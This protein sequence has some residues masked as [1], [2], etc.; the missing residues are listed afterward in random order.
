M[1]THTRSRRCLPIGALLLGI[2]AVGGSAPL[3]ASEPDID[4]RWL[5]WL[6]CWAP[7]GASD[8]AA[9]SL[10][11]V[12]RVCV[13]PAPGTAGVDLVS[14]TDGRIVS[15]VHIDAAGA[16]RPVSRDGCEGWER[17]EWS[18][19]GERVYMRSELICAG[20]I[21][22]TSSGVLAI[23][24]PTEW[25]DVQVI[26]VRDE[27]STRVARYRFLRDTTAFAIE[28][29]ASLAGRELARES[30]R[31]AA[32][33]M[34]DVADVIEASSSV[35]PAVV[36]AWL[37]QRMPHLTVDA[38]DLRALS[39][40]RVPGSVIDL[41][42]ALSR[43]ELFPERLVAR[44][45]T[46]ARI[47]Q[48]RPPVVV[49]QKEP[50]RSYPMPLYLDGYGGRGY[51]GSY[52][53]GYGGYGGYGQ[54][55]SYYRSYR[56]S[57]YATYGLNPYLLYALY[58]SYYPFHTDNPAENPVDPQPRDPARAYSR[59][60]AEPGYARPIGPSPA[61]A[62][63]RAVSGQGYTRSSGGGTATP[64]PPPRDATA[65]PRPPETP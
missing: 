17:G 51:Y 55:A 49:V 31:M 13:A 6:G 1:V 48:P 26:A 33:S 41:V 46:Y 20:G 45:Y 38:G 23:A 18:A 60:S 42:V 34:P 63:G 56:G 15:R 29:A 9:P 61:S 4:P 43:P 22:R 25:V 54:T 14:Y 35:E 8:A 7:S 12:Q 36:E 37:L 21:E 44:G 64:A 24:S 59:P 2:L 27:R 40:A 16:R 32:A 3:A 50:N 30:A 19:G 47:R 52:A 53:R 28:I 10:A 5:P 57:G 65:K 11:G 62:G 58:S 39:R